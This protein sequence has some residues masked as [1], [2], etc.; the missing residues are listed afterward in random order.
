MMKI[1][2]RE[3]EIGSSKK[4]MLFNLVNVYTTRSI[5]TWESTHVSCYLQEYH[6][7]YHGRL[8]TMKHKLG[9]VIMRYNNFLII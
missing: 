2:E 7:N 8:C 4:L 5:Y 1:E 6:R 9:Y 3:R